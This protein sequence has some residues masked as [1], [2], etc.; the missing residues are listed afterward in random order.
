VR[1]KITRWKSDPYARGSYSFLSYG[2]T[3]QDIERIAKPVGNLH[4][5][6][7]HTFKPL[8]FTHGAFLSGVREAERINQRIHV[9]NSILNEENND[10]RTHSNDSNH[11]NS[12]RRL[13][14]ILPPMSSIMP[15]SINGSIIPPLSSIQLLSK[16]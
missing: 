11:S 1:Y 3:L 8:G 16:L 9:S 5:A 4:F 14:I 12:H 2:S 7:E 6:G 10:H 13:N 15:S